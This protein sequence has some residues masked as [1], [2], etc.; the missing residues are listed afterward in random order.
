[1]NSIGLQNQGPLTPEQYTFLEGSVRET[2]KQNLVARRMVPTIGPLGFGAESISYDRLE[3]MSEAQITLSWKSDNSEDLVNFKRITDPI[4]VIQKSF[5]IN[6]RS[7][8][9]SRRQGIALDVAT[10]RF[11]AYQVALKEDHFI[12]YGHQ[13]VP[14][15]YGLAG[16]TLD[17]L[18][19]WSI[20]ENIP[21]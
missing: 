4:P 3:E 10:A 6:A 16:N 13:D 18:Y 12:F 19:N 21:K 1:M 7:L 8:A 14:G 5:R 2:L 9:A 15:L 20:P 11:A 17:T